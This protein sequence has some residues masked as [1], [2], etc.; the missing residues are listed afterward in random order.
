MNT[1]KT[2]HTT[3]LPS[4]TIDPANIAS[5]IFDVTSFIKYSKLSLTIEDDIL[6]FYKN[7]RVQGLMK[8]IIIL[9]C[10]PVIPD[11]GIYH[12]DLTDNIKAVCNTAL[13]TKFRED[14]VI[15]K[16]FSVSHNLL[17]T[18]DS[19]SDFIFQLLTMKQPNLVTVLLVTIDIPKY[20]ISIFLC[21]YAK[22]II[23]YVYV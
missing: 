13:A 17:L 22:L 7:V 16:T 1:S 20:F 3:S 10:K 5:D 4:M 2:S 11:S 12:P 18:T 6:P 21:K 8:N 15:V 23:N 14:G 9:Q 19:G